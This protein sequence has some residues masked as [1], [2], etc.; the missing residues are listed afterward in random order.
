VD[1]GQRSNVI[2]RGNQ[3]TL[4]KPSPVPLCPQQI[5]HGLPWIRTGAKLLRQLYRFCEWL[6]YF[7][8]VLILC[9]CWAEYTKL[10]LS[11]YTPRRRFG[12]RRHSSYSFS[13][14]T[15]IGVRGQRHAPGK[16][17]PVPIVQE[18]GWAPD[19]VWTQ[20]LEEK[21]LSFLH[22]QIPVCW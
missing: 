22:V 16:G 11:H 5:P 14:S 18:P 17:P 2:G 4:K 13:T 10:K 7:I 8:V 19:P 6:R 15:L 3:K 20:R 12:G 9:L 21:I 1:V